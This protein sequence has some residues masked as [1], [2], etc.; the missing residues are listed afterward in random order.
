MKKLLLVVLFLAGAA[1]MSAAQER[2]VTGKVTS[3]EDG[4]GLPGVNVVI[5]GTATGTITDID[6]NY[7]IEA[8]DEDIL[9]FSSVGYRSVS[10]AVGTHSMI[11]MVLEVDIQAL[12]EIV[13]TGYGTQIKRD[14]TGSISSVKSKELEMV[15]AI[16]V[17]NMLQGMVAGVQVFGAN[18]VPGSPT[19]VM[20]RGTNS[21]YNGTEPL[22]IIDGMILQQTSDG[23]T[24]IARNSS[25]TAQ[26]PLA[27]INPNDIESIE[28]LKDASATAIYGSRGSNGVII[29]TTKT[30]KG[31]SRGTFNIDYQG[32]VT[33]PIRSPEDI[34]FVNGDTWLELMDEARANSGQSPYDPNSRLNSNRDPNAVLD[35]SQTTN[36][37]WFD[38]VLQQGNFNDLNLSTSKSSENMNFYFAGNYR[39]DKS[40]IQRNSFDRATARTNLDFKPVNNLDVGLRA[41]VSYAV[42]QRAPNGG[43]P[44]SN[45]NIARGGYDMANSG[46]LP[47]LPIMHPTATDAD[48]NPILFDPL[49]GYNLRASM[50]YD[51][52]KND[53][54]TFR[55]IGGLF[56][57]YHLPWVKGL[58]IHAEGGYDFYSSS[59]IEWGNTVIRENS[60][61]A[62][63]QQ[64]ALKRYNY[65]AYLTYARQFGENHHLNIV[66]GAESTGQE[67]RYRNTEGDELV[68]SFPEIGTPGNVQ[69]VSN[70]LG[71]EIYFRGYFTRINY[72][73]MDRYLIGFSGRYDGVSIFTEDNRW[74]SYP[75][76]SAGWIITEEGFM[77]GIGWLNFLK[78][79]A[80]YGSTGN[81]NISQNATMTAYTGWGRY[82]DVGAGD[83]LTNIANPDVTW[84]STDLTDV[85]VDFEVFDSRLSGAVGYYNQK[86]SDMLYLV[87]IPQSSGV[88]A[89]LPRIWDNVGDMKNSGW[90]IELR[91]V[92]VDKG[93]VRWDA[94]FNITT[95]KNEVIS[96]SQGTDQLYNA[97]TNGL[98]SRP[99]DPIAFFRLARYAGIHEEGGY[100]LIYEVDLDRLAETGETVATGNLIPATRANMTQHL[101][102]NTDKTGLPTFFGGFNTSLTWNGFDFAAFFTFQGGNYI[103]DAA[104]VSQVYP[105]YGNVLRQDLVDNYWT[106]SNM[107]GA[108]YP[109]LVSN[110]RYDVINDDGSVSA[111]QRFDWQR[112]GQRH[113]KYLKKGDYMRLRTLSIGYS[114][115]STVMEKLKMQKIRIYV[116]ANNIWTVTGFDGYDPE[117]VNTGGDRN[118]NQGWVGVQIPQ[119][120]SFSAGINLGF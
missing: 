65:N 89:N 84:E 114:L 92:I 2:T 20:V 78:L 103:F 11:D 5:Q 68:G 105:S 31:Q 94:G 26:N 34:G 90:E 55:T 116:M 80:S 81:Y 64:S 52:Y 36:T 57:D 58:S 17:D 42:N 72:K 23:L 51:N 48:G 101:F 59:N 54:E 38:E 16:S 49:S 21:I 67:Q 98:V 87:P 47:Y 86:V 110:Y 22:W 9:D 119:A 76:F 118:I 8:D 44:G 12:D 75:A 6:G 13:V 70:G 82:G 113:D 106:E 60:A 107:T 71:N 77:S 28:V 56:L 18:G 108:S 83:L 61:Y 46:A 91:G 50:N 37:N 109:K 111:N 79:R 30:G 41:T 93:A 120:K 66:L 29:V 95:N 99:G 10:R 85:G 115:P 97:N 24:G 3:S 73:F 35:R 7:S 43:T 45:S 39:G 112:A 102:D 33:N 63:D 4:S 100:E 27:M 117:T 25:T 88:F 32:G 14:I 53:V 40:I 15:P 104:E 96:L 62:F 74:S 1:A 69:R 19:R